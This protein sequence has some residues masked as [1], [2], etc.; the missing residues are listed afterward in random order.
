MGTKTLAAMLAMLIGLLA[1]G[2]ISQIASL[3]VRALVGL[4]VT[5]FAYYYGY[6]LLKKV[7]EGDF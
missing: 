3:S 1:D 5:G 6:R 7:K 2:L 4:L